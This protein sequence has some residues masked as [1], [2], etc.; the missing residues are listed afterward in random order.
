MCLTQ[1]LASDMDNIKNRKSQSYIRLLCPE[2]YDEFDESY[3]KLELRTDPPTFIQLHPG[4]NELRVEEYPDL[5]YGFKWIEGQE[6]NED[7]IEIDFSHFDAKDINSIRCMFFRMPVKKI[8][9]DKMTT[10]NLT[11]A[12][13]AFASVGFYAYNILDEID[14]SSWDFSKLENAFGMFQGANIGTLRMENANLNNLKDGRKMFR[15]SNISKLILD[16]LKVNNP[17][18]IDI[19][20]YTSPLEV[21]LRR[22]KPDTIKCIIESI[23]S[24]RAQN[25]TYSPTIEWIPATYILDDNL[26]YCLE[27]IQDNKVK[28]HIMTT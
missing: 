23:E 7:I 13:M 22:C 19:E 28:C 18:R 12:K 27:K 1:N 24:K 2:Y 14:I 20:I 10:P 21:S 5:K 8:I 6:S 16:G 26:T 9:F 17:E 4:L 25:S 3:T 15:N 11:D